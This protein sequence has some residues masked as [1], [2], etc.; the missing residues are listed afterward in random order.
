MN[1]VF[2]VAGQK[3]Y[4]RATANQE[5]N[6]NPQKSSEKASVF[7]KQSK[8]KKPELATTHT[9][10]SKWLLIVFPLYRF[11]TESAKTQMYSVLKQDLG[12][13]DF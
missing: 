12:L 6:I 5:N 1:L 8:D 13:L 2:W 7:C 9:H 3:L 10:W 11:L 4:H